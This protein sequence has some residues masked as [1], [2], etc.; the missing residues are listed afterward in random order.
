MLT[1]SFFEGRDI[2]LIRRCFRL[3]RSEFDFVVKDAFGVEEIN[4][5]DFFIKLKDVKLQNLFKDMDNS[6]FIFQFI[7]LDESNKHANHRISIETT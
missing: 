6:G 4:A 7:F 5:S 1:F 3:G 2:K